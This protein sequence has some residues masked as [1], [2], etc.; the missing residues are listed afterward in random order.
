MFG[1]KPH[2]DDRDIVAGAALERD[3]DQMITRLFGGRGSRA[4]QYFFVRHMAGK[5]VGANDENVTGI[6]RT[7]CDLKFRK[8]RDTDGT[9]DD[10]FP[11]PRLRLFGCDNTVRQKVLS[12]G[13][14]AGDLRNATIANNDTSGCPQTKRMQNNRQRSEE[15]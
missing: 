7:G 11:D 2:D 10:V 5:A 13:V 3:T 12:F 6:Y 15:S 8:L 1:A 9:R 4:L 14:I